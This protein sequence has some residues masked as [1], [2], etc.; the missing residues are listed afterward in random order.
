MYKEWARLQRGQRGGSSQSRPSMV[1]GRGSR[2]RRP[3]L[4][5]LHSDYAASSNKERLEGTMDNTHLK[6][7][8]IKSAGR[9]SHLINAAYHSQCYNGELPFDSASR[10][11]FPVT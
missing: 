8:S 2:D 1:I 7:S 9:L 10:L 3:Q 11:D 5:A 4:K 6:S